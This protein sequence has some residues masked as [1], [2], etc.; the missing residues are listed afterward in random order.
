M[1]ETEVKLICPL[2][3]FIETRS[4]A[5]FVQFGPCMNCQRGHV[6]SIPL[7]KKGV[8]YFWY[9]MSCFEGYTFNGTSL[10]KVNP[11]RDFGK[12]E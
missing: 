7:R 3:L 4:K 12:D 1:P 10:G 6:T 9:C 5:R 11:I 8:D 2:I